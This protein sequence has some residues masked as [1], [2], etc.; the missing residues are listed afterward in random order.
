MNVII[1]RYA[2]IIAKYNILEWDSQPISYRFKANIRFIG[3]SILLVKEYLLPH[4]RK[5]TY[6]WQDVHDALKIRW[7]NAPHWKSVA[8][9]PHH[10]HEGEQIAPSTETSLEDV[11][12][13]I[14]AAL[15]RSETP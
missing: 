11:L 9:F 3:G 15:M 2:D 14:H 1:E 12:A 6:H 8:T 13:Y 10:R 7:D 5:Y 4:G